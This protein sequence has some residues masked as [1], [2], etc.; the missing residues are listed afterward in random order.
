MRKP[1]LSQAGTRRAIARRVLAA[2]GTLAV[3]GELT[4]KAI[5]QLVHRDAALWCRELQVQCCYRLFGVPAWLNV[6]QFK[7]MHRL[8]GRFD[9]APHIQFAGVQNRRVHFRPTTPQATPS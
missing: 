7:R 2:H 8:A 4:W 9:L 5:T 1:S 3:A 6:F